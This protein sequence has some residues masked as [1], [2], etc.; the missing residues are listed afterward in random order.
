MSAVSGPKPKQFRTPV[1]LQ[2]ILS[3]S[4]LASVSQN[5]NPILRFAILK[6]RKHRVHL[7]RPIIPHSRLLAQSP[8]RSPPPFHPGPSPICSPHYRQKV[9]LQMH[10]GEKKDILFIVTYQTLMIWPLPASGL[11]S[12]TSDCSCCVFQNLVLASYRGDL[13]MSP[14]PSFQNPL[15]SPL[16]FINCKHLSGLNSRVASSKNPALT[17]FPD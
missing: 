16:Y 5:H 17:S 13:H 15:P 2:F 1:I 12:C 7:F 9:Y 10:T 3:P 6:V 4:P 14:E 8:N 11:W